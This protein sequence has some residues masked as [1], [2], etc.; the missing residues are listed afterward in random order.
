MGNELK[1]GK[2]ASALLQS[3]ILSRTGRRRPEVLVRAGV[4]LDSAAMDFGG[5]L[6][7]LSTDPITGAAGDAGYWAV[8]ICCND[9]AVYGAEPVALLLTVLLPEGSTE[10][11]LR[12][13]AESAHR[14]AEELGIEIAGGHT[15]ITPAVRTTVLSATALGRV[16]PERL[17]TPAGA[18]ASDVLILT[19]GA[20]IEGT[21]I[22]AET[23]G[24]RL[25]AGG[26][27]EELIA[28]AMDLR[29][30]LSVV[31]DARAA[32]GAGVTAMHDP[33]EGGVLGAAY[34]MAEASGLGFVVREADVP[35]RQETRALAQVLGFDALRLISSGALMMTAPAEAAER[36]LRA[37]AE[38]GIE[39]AVIGEMLEA[40]EG[41]SVVRGAVGASRAGAVA[42]GPGAAAPKVAAELEAVEDT[43]RDEL[44]RLLHGE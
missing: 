10:A 22:L 5:D 38:A 33:T 11:D 19:K 18:R 15:E 1:S 36:V 6:L 16:S 8:H 31:P 41:R 30:Q 43:P 7:V 3:A 39:A 29:W 28:R 26:V 27:S 32:R 14:A 9:I 12:A 2:L 23:F 37:L 4:G 17:I 40:S 24:E 25:R 20:G 34:E 42:G 44:W 13:L 35:V 21:S